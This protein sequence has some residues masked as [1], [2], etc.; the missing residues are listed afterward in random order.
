MPYLT[1]PWCLT[2]QLVADEVNEYHCFTCAADRV[3]PVRELLDGPGRQQAVAGVHVHEVP[4]E[5][6]PSVPLGLRPER[7]GLSGEG[8][9]EVL[10]RA[11][12]APPSLRAG[13]TPTRRGRR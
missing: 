12:K 6:R 10:A 3:H 1:C 9:R 11:L 7:E 8:D 4:D 13:G 5:D 2:P